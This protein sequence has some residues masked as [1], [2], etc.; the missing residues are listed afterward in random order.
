MMSPKA[1]VILPFFN[2]E[3][4]LRMAL[5]SVASQSFRDFECICVDDGSTDGSAV[6]AEE[7]ARQDSRFRVIRGEHRGP[8]I[9]RNKGMAAARGECLA[10][11]DADDAYEPDFLEKMIEEYGRQAKCDIV[12]CEAWRY[13]GTTGVMQPAEQCFVAELYEAGDYLNC[14]PGMP[15]NKLFSRTFVCENGFR[16]LD[17][18]FCEDVGFVY[19][20]LAMA[21][22]IGVVRER[23]IRHRVDNAESLEH[24]KGSVGATVFYEAYLNVRDQLRARGVY[25][26]V[27]ASFI[28]RIGTA[29]RYNANAVCDLIGLRLFYDRVMPN[30]E[31]DFGL[32]GDVVSVF[33]EEL[34]A[35]CSRTFDEYVI[36][37]LRLAR[38]LPAAKAECKRLSALAESHERDLKALRQAYQGVLGSVSFRLGRALTFLPRRFWR[39]VKPSFRTRG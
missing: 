1:S 3:R 8:G 16:F 26:C 17:T 2:A 28:R 29:L 13:E 36:S 9:A 6:V 37:R 25:E 27:R 23:L 35:M 11:L 4:Y 10:F 18:P 33:D 15:W 39:F 24:M 38:Q 19:P 7:F 22:R 32:C 20:A 30:A 14:T 12:I 21:S 31:R 34:R 5:G